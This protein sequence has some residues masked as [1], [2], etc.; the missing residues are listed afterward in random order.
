V[1]KSLVL[2]L[3]VAALAITLGGALYALLGRDSP[4]LA[5]YKRVRV[6][7]S[8]GEVQAI[9]GPGEEI[10]PKSVPGVV[11]AVNPADAESAR[12]RDRRTGTQSTGRDY[13]TRI[14]PVVEG[15]LILRW[16]NGQTGE[17]ILIAFKDG[18]VCEKDY[19]DPNYL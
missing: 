18:K 11:V 6:G 9:L 10:D 8:V 1:R 4:D 2:L 3:L 16:V 12:E 13:P 15:D 14:K 17:R 7:M 5:N 19:W